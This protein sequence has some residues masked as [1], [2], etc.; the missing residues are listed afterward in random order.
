MIQLCDLELTIQSSL[1]RILCIEAALLF[2]YVLLMYVHLMLMSLLGIHLESVFAFIRT[3]L[4]VVDLAWSIG[5]GP[6]EAIEI[7]AWGNRTFWSH[8]PTTA[9]IAHLILLQP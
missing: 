1:Q 7:W 3:I 8:A 4:T 9:G 5:V 6:F 2:R